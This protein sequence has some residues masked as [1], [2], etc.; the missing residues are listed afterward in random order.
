MRIN[1]IKALGQGIYHCVSRMLEHL[2]PLDPHELELF[3]GL[4]RR[5]EVFHG[6]RILTYALMS[7][8]FH[9]LVDIDPDAEVGEP[10]VIERVA[11]LYGRDEAEATAARWERW[12]AAGQGWRAEDELAAL[13][14]RMGDV[15]EFVKTLKQRFTQSYNGRHERRGTIWEDRFKSVLL[16]IPPHFA[17]RCQGSGALLTVATYIDLNPV[18]AGLSDM[19]EGYRWSGYGEAVAG[20]SAARAGL[21][22]LHGLSVGWRRVAARYRLTLAA[23]GEERIVGR[24]EAERPRPGISSGE[25]AL[26]QERKGELTLAE[27]MRCRVRYLSESLVLGSAAFVEGVM[28]GNRR[29]FPRHRRAVP[30]RHAD[31]GGLC[32]ERRFRGEVIIPYKV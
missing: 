30:L 27:A 12:R 31:F 15:S 25:V 32:A 11:A 22:R 16:E 23:L 28:A 29:H 5:C 4:M 9:I 3:H 18:R 19:P 7:N 1:R 8:H 10:G 21:L 20:G 14:A 2:P 24:G 26:I 6:V 13:R 17:E